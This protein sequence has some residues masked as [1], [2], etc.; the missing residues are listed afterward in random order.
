MN[1]HD[2]FF[3]MSKLTLEDYFIRCIVSEVEASDLRSSRRNFIALS[4][5]EHLGLVILSFLLRWI[6]KTEYRPALNENHD[7]GAVCDIASNKYIPIEQTF[8]FEQKWDDHVQDGIKDVLTR[9]NKK[10]QNYADGAILLIFVNAQGDLDLTSIMSE[11]QNSYFESVVI[12]GPSGTGKF[13]YIVILVKEAHKIC[14]RQLN[15]S[16][17]PVTGVCTID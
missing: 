6:N 17:D 14:D 3:V 4:P 13:D 1:N 12:I 10:G 2:Y 9:K 7:D 15:L 5:R 16:I 11:L 8:V